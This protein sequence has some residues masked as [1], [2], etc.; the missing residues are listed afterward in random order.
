VIPLLSQDDARAIAQRFGLDP[1]FTSRNVI[2]MLL[3]HAEAFIPNFQMV[4]VLLRPESLDPRLRELILLRVNWRT[5]T[6]YAFA[7]HIRAGRELG[8]S[9][10]EIYGVRHPANCPAFSET[11]R[12]VLNLVDELLVGTTISEETVTSL[13]QEFSII[14]IMSM[15]TL[16]GNM[17]LTIPLLKLAKVPIDEGLE[18]WP[19]GEGPDP[20]TVI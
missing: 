10:E 9:R 2:R 11:D 18:G 16:V 20:A 1:E 3:H 12:L 7:Q 17:R 5:G 19:D 4:A 13:R 8:M 15:V 14:N 6:E